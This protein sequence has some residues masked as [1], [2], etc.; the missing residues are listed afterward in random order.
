MGV[1]MG[2]WWRSRALAAA[3]GVALV[4]VALL[5]SA[6][7]SSSMV[8]TS[9]DASTTLTGSLTADLNCGSEGAAVAGAMMSKAATATGSATPAQAIHDY[10]ATSPAIAPPIASLR[11]ATFEPARPPR[12]DGP[13]QGVTSAGTVPVGVVGGDPT[14]TAHE[15]QLQWFVHR[16]T[17]GRVSAVIVVSNDGVGW[18]VGTFEYCMPGVEAPGGPTQTT[19]STTIMGSP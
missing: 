6:C 17:A 19:T 11:T 18:M 16:G 12:T 14:A 8:G 10:L 9:G 5:A 7:G 15:P 1:T 13:V 2:R 4:G 3:A